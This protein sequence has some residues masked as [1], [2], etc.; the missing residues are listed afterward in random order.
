MSHNHILSLVMD[1]VREKW[2]IK[3][4][5]LLTSYGS[6]SE[7]QEIDTS[8]GENNFA[9]KIYLENASISDQFTPRLWGYNTK[10][11]Y[12]PYLK[13]KRRLRIAQKIKD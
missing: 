11:R 7:I 2:K 9:I 1:G 12:R 13:F 10:I 8:P 3:I 6:S 5:I 4:S